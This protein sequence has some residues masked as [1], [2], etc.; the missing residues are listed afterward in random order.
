MTSKVVWESSIKGFEHFQ[1]LSQTGSVI[2]I[3]NKPANWNPFFHNTR[4][5]DNLKPASDEGTNY[6]G[7]WVGLYQKGPS[8]L[9]SLK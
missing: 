6:P 3:A 7:G 9:F 1:V 4:F 2:L 5:S 8:L